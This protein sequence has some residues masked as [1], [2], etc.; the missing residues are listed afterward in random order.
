MARCDGRRQ[1]GQLRSSWLRGVSTPTATAPA[2][3]P[4]EGTS[5][6]PAALKAV[7]LA[8]FRAKVLVD[9]AGYSLYVFGPTG[10]GE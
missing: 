9:G 8:Q 10:A 7:Y 3:A 1:R 2:R 4:Q 5:A 6:A